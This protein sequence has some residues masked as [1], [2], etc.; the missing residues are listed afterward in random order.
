MQE[1]FTKEQVI[2]AIRLTARGVAKI[3]D[4][5][6]AMLEL[7]CLPQSL[8]DIVMIETVKA[9]LERKALEIER[10]YS[11]FNISLN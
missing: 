2:A 6:K 1:L 7:E 3:E 10:I 11:T 5:D 8:S 9:S 4:I